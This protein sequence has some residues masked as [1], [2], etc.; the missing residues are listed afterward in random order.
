M[1]V[2]ARRQHGGFQEQ[3]HLLVGIIGKPLQRLP[4]VPQRLGGVGIL[5][6]SLAGDGLLSGRERRATAASTL[7]S[8]CSRRVSPTAIGLFRRACASLSHRR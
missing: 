5:S 8:N 4:F 1:L 7:K 6:G 3:I 2:K